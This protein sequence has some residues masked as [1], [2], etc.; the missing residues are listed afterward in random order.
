MHR[1]ELV[2]LRKKQTLWMGLFLYAQGVALSPDTKAR[3]IHNSS[4]QI[5]S[6]EEHS[7]T[8]IVADSY[9]ASFMQNSIQKH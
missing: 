6:I 1:E 9:I 7:L 4:V 3:S 2:A 5:P 8:H